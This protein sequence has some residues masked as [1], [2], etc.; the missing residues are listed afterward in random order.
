MLELSNL[1]MYE[2]YYDKSQPSFGE[3]NKQSHYMET[4]SFVI[5]VNTNDIIKIL[6]KLVNFFDFINFNE[7]PNLLRKR[8]KV[9]R[10]FQKETPK[11][12]WK[13]EIF[14]LRSQMYEFKCGD[15]SKNILKGIF[16]SQTRIIRFEELKKSL[17]RSGFIKKWNNNFFS[18]K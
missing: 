18:F 13:A 5:T 12:V 10:N 11:T 7:N 3:I 1:L 4:D 2:K 9:I 14:C 15:D 16:K 8:K 6:Q 17:D